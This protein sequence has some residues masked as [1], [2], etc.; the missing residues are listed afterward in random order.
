[1][2]TIFD[3]HRVLAASIFKNTL[4]DQTKANVYFTFGHHLPWS[5]ETSPNIANTSV[6][7]TYELWKS[8]IG[9]KKITGNDIQHAIPRYDWVINNV[10]TQ[11]DHLATTLGQDNVKFYIVNSD[12]NVYKC[13]YNNNS[14]NS[15]V[16]PT[17]TNPTNVT[18][19]ADGYVW[20]FMYSISSADQ[21]R[22]TTGSYMPVKTLLTDDGSIQWDV[23]AGTTDGAIYAIQ[24][25]SGGTG[26]SN[27]SN[28]VITISGDG[29][30]ATATANINALS[31]AVHTITLTDY[32]TGYTNA[33]VIISGG[34]GTGAAGRAIIGPPGGHGRNPLYELNGKN[35]ILN[36]RL[37]NTEGDIISVSNEFRQ[38]AIVNNPLIYGALTPA[39]NNAYSQTTDLTVSGIGSNYMEDEIVYQGISVATSTFSAL[40]VEY[41]SGNTVVR[42][43]NTQ[44]T[45][46]SDP[47]IG[48]TSSASKYVTSI[49]YPDLKVNSGNFLY[50]DNIKPITRNENQSEDFKILIKW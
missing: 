17:A 30:A 28:L 11:Y 29:A 37:I 4:S 39:G 16:E 1:M 9:A 13:L 34:S 21:I 2:P 5:N 38:I 6:A 12:F 15:T 8:M 20:K 19:T 47:L 26:Y 7:T 23:Q 36:P 48:A 33:T 24:L 31:T 22:F 50:A 18:Q 27:V 42:V 49:N 25:T 3:N 32:G 43:T 10:Y 14:S 41:D 45:P 44:G 40:V 46:I 35:L